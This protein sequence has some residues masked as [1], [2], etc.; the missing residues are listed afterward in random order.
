MPSAANVQVAVTGSVYVAAT[1][2]TAPTNSTASWAGGFT[3]LGY[4]SA[5]GVEEGYSDTTKDIRA[6]QGGTLVRR[7]ITET[8]AT[9]HFT[10]LESTRT[11]L[12]LFHKGSTLAGTGPWSM[13]VKSPTPDHRSFGFDVLDGT[14]HIRIYVADGEVTSRGNIVYKHDEPISYEITVT[15]YPSSSDVVCTKFSDIVGLGT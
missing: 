6:W 7:L 2:A 1:T 11:A 5:D 15:A 9:F 10:V 12:E 14:E 3:A 13:D 8:E 4:I